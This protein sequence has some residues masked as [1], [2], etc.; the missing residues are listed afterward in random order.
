[1]LAKLADN[2]TEKLG[3]YLLNDVKYI[4]PLII[5]RTD[6]SESSS[7]LEDNKIYS[8]VNNLNSTGFQINNKVLNFIL[9]KGEIKNKNQNY[10]L[11]VIKTIK[12]NN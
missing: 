3:G 10:V 1:M 2:N 6:L 7:F 5:Q 4:E 8:L 9:K 12:L 11:L